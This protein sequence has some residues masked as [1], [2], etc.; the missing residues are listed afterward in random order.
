MVLASFLLV[1]PGRLSAAESPPAGEPAAT[2]PAAPA[3]GVTIPAK[4]AAAPP[5]GASE[6]ATA[7]ASTAGAPEP[8]KEAAAPPSGASEPATA[9]APAGPAGGQSS[10]PAAPAR[11]GFGRRLGSSG[12]KPK[13]PFESEA[14]LSIS[15]LTIL[16]LLPVGFEN[17]AQLILRRAI[18]GEGLMALNRHV[19]GALSLKINPAYAKIGPVVEIQPIAL[20]KMR[21]GYEFVNYFGTFGFPHSYPAPNWDYLADLQN[22]KPDEGYVSRGHHVYLEPTVMLAAGKGVLMSKWSF[23]YWNIDLKPGDTVFFDP[24]PNGLVPGRGWVISTD[25]DLLRAGSRVSVGLRYSGVWPQFAADQASNPA[26]GSRHRLGPVAAI[27]FPRKSPAAV[28]QQPTLVTL[29]GWYLNGDFPSAASR[30]FIVLAF[31]FTTDLRR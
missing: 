17:Q 21:L 4:D 19:S 25:T 15:D 8:A 5:S 22:A 28:I 18:P 20:L 26:A 30:T 10:E 6:P 23:E 24:T 12:D 16:R 31:S 7:P 29:V 2:G 1:S 11:R 3:A 14:P 9:A 13:S 27:T